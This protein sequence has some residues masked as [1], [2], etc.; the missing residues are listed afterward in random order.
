MSYKLRSLPVVLVQKE[1]VSLRFCID[2]CEL[3]SVTKADTFPLPKI[4]DL[5]DQLGKAK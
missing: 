2:Y 5:L 4:D 1:D 3:T